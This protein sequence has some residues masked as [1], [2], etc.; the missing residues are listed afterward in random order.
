MD[1][2]RNMRLNFFVQKPIKQPTGVV[3]KENEVTHSSKK[4]SIPSAEKDMLRTQQKKSIQTLLKQNKQLLGNTV[5]RKRE[6]DLL[7]SDRLENKLII[8]ELREEGNKDKT[9]ITVYQLSIARL[10]AI[11]QKKEGE[12]KKT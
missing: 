11:V 1:N 8:K 5:D 10:E 12:S 2:T 4:H 9:K 6:L 7:R 3:N